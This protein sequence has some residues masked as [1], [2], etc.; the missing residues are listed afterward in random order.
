MQKTLICEISEVQIEITEPEESFEKENQN[1]DTKI[2]KS[3]ET[4]QQNLESLLK[5][6][7]SEA[8]NIDSFRNTV[9]ILKLKIIKLLLN[10]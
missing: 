5:P 7:E 2:E 9:E 3:E 6:D 8:P 10:N 1:S 4:F